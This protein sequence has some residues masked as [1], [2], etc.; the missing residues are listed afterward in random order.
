MSPPGGFRVQ[1]FSRGHE[2]S[3]GQSPLDGEIETTAT[4][5]HLVKLKMHILFDSLQTINVCFTET[6]EG[7]RCGLCF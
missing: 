4:N 3:W 6:P 7:N 5:D 1:Y 2:V